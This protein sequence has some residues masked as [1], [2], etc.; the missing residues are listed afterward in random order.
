MR[1]ISLLIL[2]AIVA[3]A[4]VSAQQ[5]TSG[6]YSE[7]LAITRTGLF[8]LGGWSV[9]NIAAGTYG[10]AAR[11]GQA[12]YFSQMNLFWNVINLSIAGI[13]LYGNYNTDISRLLPGEMVS[14][15]MKTEKIFLINAGTDV[16]YMGAGMLLRH[17]SG[18]STNR[19][20]MLKGYGNSVILQGAFLFVFDLVMYGILHSQRMDGSS[21]ILNEIPPVG[22]SLMTGPGFH[23]LRLAISF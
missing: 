5:S 7:S 16:I 13:G 15:M 1:R 14:E 2:V 21:G 23:G 17:Y 11:D 18:R 19:H 12:K 3:T 9:A 22:V 10:W 8:V 4:S 6:I 20:D